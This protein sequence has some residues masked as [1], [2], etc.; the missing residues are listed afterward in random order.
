MADRLTGL[1]NSYHSYSLEEALAGIAGA[2][3][4][5]VELTSV[6]GWTEHVRRN[7]GDEEIGYIKDQLAKHGLRPFGSRR[8]IGRGRV[9]QGAQHR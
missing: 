8:R 9:P 5:S 4:K 2:G 6:P 7:S 3:Y 1:T